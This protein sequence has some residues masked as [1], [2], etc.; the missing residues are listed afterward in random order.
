MLTQ[1]DY[2][3]LEQ[4]LRSNLARINYEL[5]SPNSLLKVLESV[6]SYVPSSTYQRE[7][8][9]IS[10][11]DHLKLTAALAACMYQYLDARRVTDYRDAMFTEK[12][13]QEFRT[14]QSFL[15]VSADISGIQDF[16]YTI[17][18]RGALKSLRARSFYL[19]LILEHMADEILSALNLTRA[20]LLYSGGGH[21]YLLLPNTKRVVE[22]LKEAHRDFNHW[23]YRL[24]ST[25]LYLEMAAVPVTANVLTNGG[26]EGHSSNLLGDAYQTLA[27]ELN[28]GKIRRYSSGLLPEIM[29]TE[30][31]M[32]SDMDAGRE[33]GICRTSSIELVDDVLDTG[34]VQVICRNCKSLRDIGGQL[35]RRVKPNLP[36][37]VSVQEKRPSDR[38]YLEVP[39]LEEK[40][41]YICITTQKEAE[42]T[43]K[44]DKKAY[45][46]VYS[47]NDLMTGLAYST[48][49]WM[50][51]YSKPSS[52]EA[53]HVDFEEL[54]GDSTGIKRMAVL[55]ADVD[56]LGKIFA[57]GLEQPDEKDKYRYLS[58][59]RSATLSRQL[60]L[61]FK[62]HINLICGSERHHS[63]LTGKEIAAPRSLV[64]VYSGGDDLFIVGAWN[65][66]VDFA[67]ELYQAFTRFTCER[68][69]FSAGIG[70][71]RE[72]FPISQM[73]ALTARLEEAA[74]ELDGKDA[75]ALF[76]LDRSIRE[77][78]D[79]PEVR[80]VFKWNE[81]IRGVLGEKLGYLNDRLAVEKEI[82]TSGRLA[83]GM[84]VMYRWL[85]LLNGLAAPDGR[86]NLARLAYHL[87]RME[88]TAGARGDVQDSYRELH[89]R[90]YEW[91]G[92]E[93][94]RRELVTAINLFVY[95]HR[96]TKEGDDR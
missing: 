3:R 65:E 92:N 8:P 36:L 89:R 74:K 72:G 37:I 41:A 16:I 91:A 90:V 11:F 48:N 68:L 20:N 85:I 34:E 95:Q 56:N 53:G 63:Y 25:T 49:L 79:T 42:E 5:E 60:S 58:L 52:Q 44:A 59:S 38:V 84:G 15:L 31:I 94:D 6:A 2:A 75:I 47:I 43:L 54:A 4:Y 69:H 71:F 70:F 93:K 64:I 18:S 96:K 40:V 22:V 73:A 19:E 66:V 62:K 39:C 24:Y 12:G 26:P 77:C 29:D 23:L 27:N 13:R 10:L 50:G 33:C 86:I 61:F 82:E 76:G 80:H 87:A 51:H 9:D 81:F 35:G 30:S 7:I 46:R 45:R 57:R 21:F 14:C 32:K 67:V 1:A 28:L 83:V 55:R 78:E 17:S 88:P